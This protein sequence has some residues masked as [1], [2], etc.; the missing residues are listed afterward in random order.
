MIES[1]SDKQK[2]SF[3]CIL[4]TIFK[5]SKLITNQQK[6]IFLMFKNDDHRNSNDRERKKS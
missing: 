5:N 3:K 1:T 2:R 6:R 4:N